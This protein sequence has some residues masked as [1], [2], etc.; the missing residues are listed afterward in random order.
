MNSLIQY[1]LIRLR[2]FQ[3]NISIRNS[4]SIND[5]GELTLLKFIPINYFNYCIGKINSK[6]VLEYVKN[7]YSDISENKHRILI[8]SEDFLSR[9]IILESSNYKLKEISSY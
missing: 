2:A 8:D 6:E 9:E 4:I 1:D 3:K 5:T 7:F